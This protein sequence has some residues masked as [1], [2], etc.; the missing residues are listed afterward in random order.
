VK[1]RTPQ[2]A[3]VEDHPTSDATKAVKLVQAA[4]VVKQPTAQQALVEDHP[5]S[6]AAKA[7]KLVQ[8]AQ[9]VKQPTAKERK[10]VAAS[11]LAALF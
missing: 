2:Q 5:T 4:Q 7:V 10:Q 1:R 6:D 9:A 11:T 3:L 8:A